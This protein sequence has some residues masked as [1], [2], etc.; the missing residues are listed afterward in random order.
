MDNCFKC[1][2]KTTFTQCNNNYLLAEDNTCIDKNL[3]LQNLYYLDSTTQKY[4]NCK[5]ISNC[6]KCL[7]AT[8]CIACNTNYYFVEDENNAISCQNIDLTRY[9]WTDS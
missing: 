5:K 8:E 6:Q 3:F 1:S 4:F 7:S 9:F 2:D